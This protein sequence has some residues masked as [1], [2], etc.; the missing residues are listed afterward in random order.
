MPL[1]ALAFPAFD[2]VAVQIGPL[3]VRWYALAYLSGI[4]FGWWLARR[5]VRSE[6]LWGG[7]PP[8]T[9]GDIDDLIVWVTLGIVAGGRLGFVLFYNP[10]YYLQHPLEAFALWQGGMAF[11]GGL[12]GAALAALLF[13]RARQ[14]PALSLM[15]V[16]CA[17]APIGLLLGRIANFIKPELWGRPTD[18][19]WGIV[20]PGAGPEPR[21]PSQLYE[22]ALEGLLLFLVLQAVVVF[23]GLR[24]PGLVGGIFLVGY[25]LARI[26]AEQFRMPDEQIGFLAGGLTMGAILSVPMLLIG[27][28]LILYALRRRPA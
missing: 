11:H 2:P 13:A 22:A 6:T 8:L 21:H 25:A 4:V 12:A 28:G 16:C 10:A 19:P 17:V 24:R 27:A 20:F 15:D 14:L 9:P 5:Y 7:K 23:G 26:V 18:V 3:A 1:A